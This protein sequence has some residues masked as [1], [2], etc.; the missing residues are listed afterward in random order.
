MAYGI[1]CPHCDVGTS[2]SP[3]GEAKHIEMNLGNLTQAQRATESIHDTES[4][5]FFGLNGCQACSKAFPLRGKADHTSLVDQH[6][7]LDTLE[8]LWPTRYRAVPQ[9]ISPTVRKAIEDASAAS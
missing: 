6:V 5:F 3:V 7:R 2:Y 8:A 1:L 4:G 9:E